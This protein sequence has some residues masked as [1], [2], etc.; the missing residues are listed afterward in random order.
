[1]PAGPDASFSSGAGS[2]DVLPDGDDILLTVAAGTPWDE[3]V[4]H[5]VAEGWSGLE[6]M[7]GIPGLTGATPVQNVGAYGAEIADVLTGLSVLDRSTGHVRAW[8]P[9]ECQ[10]GFR[11]SAFKHTDRYVVLDVTVR[12][13]RRGQSVPIRYAEL[14]RRL[15]IEPGATAP[16]GQVRGHRAGPASQQGHGPGRGRS[17]LVERGV[18]LRQ[19]RC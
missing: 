16:L 19:P 12:L 3:L 5:T 17:R 7:S 14:A 13:A 2:L 9:E 6:T 4:E 15:G 10:F 18:V 11:T 8:T 1:M